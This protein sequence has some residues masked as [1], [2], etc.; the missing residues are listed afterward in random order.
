MVV[1][2][3]IFNYHLFFSPIYL[4]VDIAWL[5]PRATAAI[6]PLDRLDTATPNTQFPICHICHI[7]RFC[8]RQLRTQL[9]NHF[10]PKYDYSYSPNFLYNWHQTIA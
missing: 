7:C 2:W 4:G 8:D 6:R 5:T 10:S 1:V 9:G 3:T